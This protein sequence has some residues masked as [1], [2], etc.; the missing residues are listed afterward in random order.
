MHTT[1]DG[2][3]P[4]V[5]ANVLDRSGAPVEGLYAAGEVAGGIFGT[6]RLGGAGLTN[7][8]VMGR[9][10]GA[11]AARVARGATGATAAKSSAAKPA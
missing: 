10:A 8:L 3:A 5:N 7:C 1:L 6:D 9:R 4:D 2:I 11:E